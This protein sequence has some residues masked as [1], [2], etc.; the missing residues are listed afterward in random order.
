V[1]SFD[2]QRPCIEEIIIGKQELQIMINSRHNNLNCL[3]V[4]GKATQT[5][6]CETIL[7]L[8]RTTEQF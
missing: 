7:V 2:G 4:E 1:A 8:L 5:G 3:S 6:L